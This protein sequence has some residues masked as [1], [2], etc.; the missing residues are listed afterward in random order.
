MASGATGVGLALPPARNRGSLRRPQGKPAS[1]G[2]GDQ[3]PPGRGPRPPDA[4]F[5]RPPL[6][7]GR[8]LPGLPGTRPVTPETPV[9][10]AARSRPC[11]LTGGSPIRILTVIAAAAAALI[12]LLPARAA[13]PRHWH[14]PAWWLRQAACIRSHEGWPTAATGNSYEGSYQ[15]LRSTWESVGGAVASSGHWAS[16]APL[17]EQTYRAWLVWSRDGGSWREWGTAG[18]CGLR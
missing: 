8:S 5:F 18:M 1:R 10:R 11:P 2:H 3:A 7:T 15:F 16:V 13:V 9:S 17:R 4:P 14:P 12:L 6:A